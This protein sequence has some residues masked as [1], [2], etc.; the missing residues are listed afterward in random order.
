MSLSLLYVFLIFCDIDFFKKVN[1]TYGHRAGDL[2]LASFT[3]LI[4]DQN[5]KD[6]DWLARYGGEEFLIISPETTL[7]DA[8]ALAERIR[9]AVAEHQV[10]YIDIT[11][12]ITSSF[13]VCELSHDQMPD[14]VWE[15]IKIADKKLYESK[16]NGRNRVTF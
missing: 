8:A 1:D 13:G 7:S 2:I 4:Q 6:I 10:V 14:N 9:K 3:D 11:I 15:L 5:R 16:E 12:G